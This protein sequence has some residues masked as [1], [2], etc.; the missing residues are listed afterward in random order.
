MAKVGRPAT[1][2]SVKE[3]FSSGSGRKLWKEGLAERENVGN[4]FG[5]FDDGKYRAKVVKAFTAMSNN[6]GRPQNVLGYKFVAGEYKGQTKYHY[7]GLDNKVG[8]GIAL[9]T[10]KKLGYDIEDIDELD[11]TDRQIQKDQPEIEIRLLTK[12]DYQ[13]VAVV[14]LVDSAESDSEE[15]DDA[16]VE[17]KPKPRKGKTAE[18]DDDTEDEDEDSEKGDKDDEGDSEESDDDEDEDKEDDEES[19]DE[20]EDEEKKPKAKKGKDK[21]SKSEDEEDKDE[22]DEEDED[23][24]KEDGESDEVVLEV[25]MKL[26]VKIDDESVKAKIVKVDEKAREVRV[27]L[28]DGSKVTISVDDIEEVL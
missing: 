17:E 9:E 5:E 2:K 26:K 27:K 11:D 22:A 8:I 21:K 28:A 24:E 18:S 14:G 4:G 15:D 16:D 6:S 1:A 19:E 7:Q 13:N 20:D 3:Y 12:G 25:G 10:L 23:E